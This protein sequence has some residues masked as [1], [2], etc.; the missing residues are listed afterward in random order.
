MWTNRAWREDTRQN[1]SRKAVTMMPD[2][3]TKAKW[4]AVMAAIREG[5]GF[6]YLLVLLVLLLSLV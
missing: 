2:I 6:S 1:A 5:G 4:S 3:F